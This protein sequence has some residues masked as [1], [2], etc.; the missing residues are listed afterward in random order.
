MY[1]LPSAPHALAHTATIFSRSTNEV[2]CGFEGNNDI[3]GIGIR[4]GIYAQILAVWFANY[5]LFSE[6]QVLRDFVSIFSVAPL[7]V[8]PM[9]MQ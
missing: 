9:C 7:I 5:F 2:Q 1:L 4:I 3:Y 6:A 8:A